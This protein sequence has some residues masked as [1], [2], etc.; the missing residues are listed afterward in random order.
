M[1]SDW[2][3]NVHFFLILLGVGVISLLIQI[4]VFSFSPCEHLLLSAYLFNI[5]FAAFSV[6]ALLQ[7]NKKNPAITGFVFLGLSLMKFIV[8]YIAFYPVYYDDRTISRQEFFSFFTPYAVSLAAEIVY[9][10]K[11]LRNS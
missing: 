4:F 10:S 3:K 8:F 11:A 1:M 7:I 9:L 6:F 2:K 5:L